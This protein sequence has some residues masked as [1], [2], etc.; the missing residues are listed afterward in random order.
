MLV[1]RRENVWLAVYLRAEAVGRTAPARARWKMV[2]C[3]VGVWMLMILKS[4]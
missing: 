3:I 1:G 4:S 2:K